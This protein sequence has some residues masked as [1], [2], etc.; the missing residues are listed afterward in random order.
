MKRVRTAADTR[1]LVA[2]L[3]GFVV[4]TAPPRVQITAVTHE[5]GF[6]RHSLEYRSGDGDRTAA[7][8]LVPKTPGPH[9]GVLALHQ[10]NSQWEMGKSEILG[11]GGDRYQAFGPALARRGVCVLAPDAVG[12]ESRQ[13]RPG[14]GEEFAPPQSRPG[15]TPAGWLQFYNQMC[16]RLVRGDLLM[17]KV[18]MD[19]SLALSVLTRHETV[20]PA[21]IGAVGH[22]FGG[23]T[24]LFLSALDT[25][26]AF[27]CVSGAACTYRHKLRNGV[28]LDMALVIPGCVE[29][30]D[31]DD[32]VKCV[33]P[34]RI[35]LVSSE[36]D[37]M[38]GDVHEIVRSARVSFEEQGCSPH[39]GHFHG[40]GPHAL[41]RIRFEEIVEWMSAI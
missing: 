9:P 26:I 1:E 8:M 22:S 38:S 35:F 11:L 20:D 4:Q 10:H 12:F 27:A 31:I 5:E 32:L 36:D 30:F 3:V 23:N 25:R 37:P 28:G 16:H 29:L 17:R 33:A 15:G 7:F 6:D 39:L 34:R 2:E 41:D 40:E 14:S 21:R 19:A 24:V 18:L 13:G